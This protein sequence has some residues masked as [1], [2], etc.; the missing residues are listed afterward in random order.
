MVGGGGSNKNWP[1]PFNLDIITEIIKLMSIVDFI[2]N[3]TILYLNCN[4][5]LIQVKYKMNTDKK[6]ESQLIS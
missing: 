1:K 5:P 6:C 3:H 4:P 2:S